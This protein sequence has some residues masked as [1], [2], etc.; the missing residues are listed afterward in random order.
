MTPEE[1]KRYLLHAYKYLPSKIEDATR[2]INDGIN[3]M[4]SPILSISFGKDSVVMANLILT[5]Y[6]QSPL[7]YVNCGLGDEWPDTERVKQEW[8]ARWNCDFTELEGPSILE[9]FEQSGLFLQDEEPDA[10]KRKAE[11]QYSHSLGTILDNYS[12]RNGFDG[13]FIGLRREESRNRDRLFQMRGSLYYAKGRRL[14]VSCPLENWTG[15]DIW[16]YIVFNNLPYNELYDLSPVSRE[17]AR[18]GAM[19]GTRGF[20][21][22]RLG[23]LKQMYPSEFNQLATKY[24]EIRRYL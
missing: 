21:Y 15:A 11:K 13:S 19:F 14:W 12:H 22:G 1:R 18:N 6:P 23:L 4:Q 3:A 24:P 16:A 7:V 8:L 5:R 17:S 10:T 2:I 9:Y 20:R